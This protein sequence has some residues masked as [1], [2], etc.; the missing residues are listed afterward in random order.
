MTKGW[1]EPND[2]FSLGAMVPDSIIQYMWQLYTCTM[3]YKHYKHGLYM[4]KK[5]E[6]GE[7][8][9]GAQINETEKAAQTQ[10]DVIRQEVA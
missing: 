3:N 6:V 1:Q 7:G 5:H 4:L 10:V 9:G 8:A 2:V